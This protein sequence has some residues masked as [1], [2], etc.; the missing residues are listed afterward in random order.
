[1]DWHEFCLR[2]EVADVRHFRAACYDPES[3]VLCSL[4]VSPASVTQGGSPYR[5]TVVHNSFTNSREQVV[6]RTSLSLPHTACQ[7]F[8]NV[9]ATVNLVLHSLDMMF[10][11]QHWV[12]GHPKDLWVLFGGD[13][14]TL[15]LMGSSLLTSLLHTMNRRQEGGKNI[16]QEGENRSEE[17]KFSR[18]PRA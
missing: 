11:S 3:T 10:E 13:C 9:C 16:A 15:I 18:P 1:M 12:Q 7:G 6:A 5:R 17:R 4:Q 8:Q 14:Y 2:V